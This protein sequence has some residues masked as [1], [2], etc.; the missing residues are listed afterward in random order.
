MRQTAFAAFKPLQ[1]GNHFGRADQFCR[2]RIRTVFALA[3]EP[4]HDN[5]GQ[6]TEQHLQ[7]HR[8]GKINA[9]IILAITALRHRAGNNPRKK[10]HKRIHNALNQRQSYHVA[11]ADVRHFVCQHGFHFIAR[12]IVQQAGRYGDQRAVFGGTGGKRI[13]LG[14]MVHRHFR[15]LDIPLACLVFHRFQQPR[16]HFGSRRSNHFRAHRRFGH[17]FGKQQRN[18]RTGESDHG[19]IRQNAAGIVCTVQAGNVQDNVD[20]DQHGNIGR[21]EKENALHV[22]PSVWFIRIKI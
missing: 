21:Q 20:H 3:A 2:P 8:Y 11:I 7:H 15:H 16:F 22:C 5:A 19:G 10:H 1:S 9:L 18:N 14:R 4:H 6:E 12:H 13:R 17:A